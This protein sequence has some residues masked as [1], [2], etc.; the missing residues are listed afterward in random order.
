MPPCV[1]LRG[2]GRTYAT[3]LAPVTALADVSLEVEQGE[4]LSLL[5]PSG[6]G[7]STLLRCIAGL[8]QPSCGQVEVRGQRLTGPPDGIGM[9]FQRDVLLD[10]RTTLD[11]VTIAA[12]FQGHSRRGAEGAALATRA[13]A[14]LDR[15][16]LGRLA[17]RYP[18][19]LSGG[20]RQRVAICRA[21]LCKPEILLM[22][23]PFGALDA[24]TRDD[25]NVEL[26]RITME[27][28]DS[29]NRTVVFV[30]HS[31]A[32]AVYLSD[33]VAVMSA[34]PGRVADIFRID[35][36]RPRALTVREAPEF[37]RHVAAIRAVFT[38]LGVAQH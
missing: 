35:L 38:R 30:T 37:T 9:V 33:R 14:L 32:E 24:M 1:A 15:F 28:E 23:E 8:D 20:Q 10:W 36:P 18:W 34:G 4:F 19:E 13:R 3:R 21:L 22:D 17:D 26:A 6:C 27:G 7:K 5:G 2:V 11:N 25:L 16:G 12:E 31:I 29:A